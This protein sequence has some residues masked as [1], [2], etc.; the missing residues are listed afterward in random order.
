MGC[1][2]LKKNVWF[3]NMLPKNYEI[4]FATGEIV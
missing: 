4:S 2:Q 1:T 3:K